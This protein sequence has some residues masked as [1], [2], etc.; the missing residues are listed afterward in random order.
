MVLPLR[1]GGHC[2]TLRSLLAA[3]IT[4][5]PRRGIPQPVLALT[6]AVGGGLDHA[7]ADRGRE[8]SV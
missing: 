6:I 8:Q 3:L 1:E 2:T 4:R 7:E 5:R